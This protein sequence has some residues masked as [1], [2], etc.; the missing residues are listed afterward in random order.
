MVLRLH[1][2]LAN[3]KDWLFEDIALRYKRKTILSTRHRRAQVVSYTVASASYI[4]ASSLSKA[5]G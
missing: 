4:Y 1:R 2:T 3:N 5:T